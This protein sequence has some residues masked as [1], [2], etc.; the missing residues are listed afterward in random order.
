MHLS[1]YPATK[2][3]KR[4]EVTATEQLILGDRNVK[5]RFM[6]PPQAKPLPITLTD[7][8]GLPAAN[9]FPD[10]LGH[11]SVPQAVNQRMSEA[12]KALTG[13]RQLVLL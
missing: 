11:P 4:F 6:Q 2:F 12:V 9:L 1:F 5:H 10:I 13:L 7:P 8:L 3:S